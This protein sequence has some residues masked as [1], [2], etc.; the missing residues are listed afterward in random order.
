MNQSVLKSPIAVALWLLPI[1][2][3]SGQGLVNFSNDSAILT[4]PPDRLIRF[5]NP[6]E[7]APTNSAGEA[8]FGTNLQVQLYYGA[9]TATQEYDLIPVANLPA[10]LPPS[11]APNHGRWEGGGMRTLEGFASGQVVLQVRVWD[12]RN[13]LTFEEAVYNPNPAGTHCD[14]WGKGAPFTYQI[15]TNGSPASSFSMSNFQGFA[16]GSL[17]SPAYIPRSPTNQTVVAGQR[18][19]LSASVG[20]TCPFTFM[21]QFN[22]TNLPGAT[23]LPFIINAVQL[24]DAGNYRLI[25]TNPYNNPSAPPATSAVATLT[26]LWP[27]LAISQPNPTQAHVTWSTSL[28]G[29]APESASN[30]SGSPWQAVTNTPS[31]QGTNFLL[32]EVP[33]VAQKYFR[34][35][36]P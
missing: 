19:V 7:C 35:R 29:F 36:K 6:G 4:S 13:G 20:G 2:A 26:V 11:S 3:V 22:G 27:M 18:A 1:G 12:I 25:A 21:W 30:L 28:N 33:S 8:A 5:V 15:P 32:I 34:L 10:H 31:V 14:C 23:T 17:A 24:S 16:V 9:T